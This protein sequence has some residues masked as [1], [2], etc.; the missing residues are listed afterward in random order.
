MRLIAVTVRQLSFRSGWL[1]GR[2]AC[3]EDESRNL[4]PECC[5]IG[6]LEVVMPFHEPFTGLENRE[7]LVLVHAAGGNSRLFPYD[8]L[9]FDFSVVSCRIVNQPAARNQLRRLRAHVFDS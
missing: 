6:S 7:T 3:A 1:T 9:A 5:R 4:G 2:C 8:S